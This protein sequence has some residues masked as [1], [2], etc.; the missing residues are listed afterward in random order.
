MFLFIRWRSPM[1]WCQGM[2]LDERMD[3]WMDGWMDEMLLRIKTIFQSPRDKFVE[4]TLKYFPPLSCSR[5]GRHLSSLRGSADQFFLCLCFLLFPFPLSCSRPGL[6]KLR[7]DCGNIF[8]MVLLPLT[9]PPDSLMHH[10]FIT[11]PRIPDV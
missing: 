10:H 2:L 4:R 5:P 7:P 11:L 1:Q 3:G 8:L 9:T 6:S